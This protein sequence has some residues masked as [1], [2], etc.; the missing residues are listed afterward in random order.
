MTV[1]TAGCGEHS[2]DLAGLCSDVSPILSSLQG[3]DGGTVGAGSSCAPLQLL[4]KAVAQ[5]QT[6]PSAE[7]SFFLAFCS[8]CAFFFRVITSDDFSDAILLLHLALQSFFC[9][10][11]P[12]YCRLVFLT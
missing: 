12:L 11:Y 10:F 8:E 2:S 5:P 7:L 4:P 3:M 1:G 9:S 6:A